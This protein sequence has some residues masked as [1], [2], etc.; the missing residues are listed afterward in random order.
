MQP[1][2][3][4]LVTRVIR[5]NTGQDVSLTAEA[6]LISSGYLDSISM[7][8][9]VIALQD[10]FAVQLEMEDM[11]VENFENVRA[12]SALVERRSTQRH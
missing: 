4:S 1:Q 10:A 2:I 3:S 6:P 5:E 7:V 12:I 9:L 11:V 8:S